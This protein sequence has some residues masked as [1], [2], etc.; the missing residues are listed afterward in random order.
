MSEFVFSDLVMPI[1][2][3]FG[4]IFSNRLMDSM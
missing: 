4:Y 2:I 3:I 1:C